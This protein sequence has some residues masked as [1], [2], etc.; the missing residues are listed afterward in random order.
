[1]VSPTIRKVLNSSLDSVLYVCKG[2][3]HKV[4]IIVSEAE[5]RVEWKKSAVVTHF[6]RPA[7][8]SWVSSDIGNEGSQDLGGHSDD[9]LCTF[10]GSE[11]EFTGPSYS[12]HVRVH[13]CPCFICAVSLQLVC[14]CHGNGTRLCHHLGSYSVLPQESC[15]QKFQASQVA[16]VLVCLYGRLFSSGTYTYVI[17]VYF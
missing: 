15:S 1:M 8:K 6:T 4:N 10:L 14:G 7:Y 17:N 13:P 5:A 9:T 2:W 3:F 11:M 16:R 12:C